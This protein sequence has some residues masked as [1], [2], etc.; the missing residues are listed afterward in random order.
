MN[1]RWKIRKA[2]R[3]GATVMAVAAEMMAMLT[4]VSGANNDSPTVSGRVAGWPG[5]GR[6]PPY[7]ATAGRPGTMSTASPSSTALPATSQWQSKRTRRL[8]G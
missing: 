4:P 1:C 8:A 3:K 2:S 5:A 6:A 7:A